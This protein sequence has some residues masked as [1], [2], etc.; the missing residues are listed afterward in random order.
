MGELKA[1]DVDIDTV[2]QKVNKLAKRYVKEK[3]S[4]K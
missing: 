1:M 4:G 2:A 3:L